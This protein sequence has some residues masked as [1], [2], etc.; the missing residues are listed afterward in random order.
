MEKLKFEDAME[1]L[2]EI[3][4]ALETGDL[5]LER[6]LEVFEEGVK[7]SNVCQ[8]ELKK[9]DARVQLLMKNLNGEFE[10]EDFEE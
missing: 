1:R 6:S 5:S 9:A 3:V 7:L 10:V 2:E 8:Q 4:E